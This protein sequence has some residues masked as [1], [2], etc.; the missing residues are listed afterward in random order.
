[1]ITGTIDSLRPLQGFGF[2][3][4]EGKR[5]KVFFH[6]EAVDGDGFAQLREGQRVTFQES[7]DPLDPRRTRADRVTPSDD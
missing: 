3:A 7:A 6:R 1:M 4:A 5:Y 2:I